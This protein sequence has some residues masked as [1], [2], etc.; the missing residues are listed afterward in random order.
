MNYENKLYDDNIKIYDNLIHC[1]NLLSHDDIK[2]LSD[3]IEKGKVSASDDDRG[4]N[5]Y[6]IQTPK[7]L[8]NFFKKKISYILRTISIDC[9]DIKLIDSI[10]SSLLES[11]DIYSFI[12]LYIRDILSQGMRTHY[13]RN[14]D[15]NMT[16]S[17]GCDAIF[18]FNNN[19]IL[20]SDGDI[21][22][23][24]GNKLYH[25]VQIIDTQK[26]Q[27][28]LEPYSRAVFQYRHKVNL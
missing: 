5:F 28:F 14:S 11:N 23:F 8:I 20:I 19:K 24:N 15:W 9:H 25:S 7:K 3:I 4:D 17:F 13:D 10:Q 12:S 18:N 21:V 27:P 22:I 6:V 1:K 26:T 2:L 16:I